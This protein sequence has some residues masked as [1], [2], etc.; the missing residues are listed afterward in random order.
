MAAPISAAQTTPQQ[1]KAEKEAAALKAREA[2]EARIDAD[3]VQMSDVVEALS[4]NLGQLHFLR[5]L[6]FGDKDQYWRDFAAKMLNIEAEDNPG[7]QEYLT[8]AFNAGYTQEQ[9]R[10]TT[11]T[12]NVSVDAAAL[13][14][15]GRHLASMLGDPNRDF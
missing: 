6:C 13:A 11:C 2:A 5:R 9:E 7:R 15:N 4:K 10:F 1:T 8:R 14:E 3:M 12:P